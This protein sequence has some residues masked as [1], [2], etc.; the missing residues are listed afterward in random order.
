MRPKILILGGTAQA[1]AEAAR[2]TVKGDCDVITS[3]AG[4]TSKPAALGGAVRVGGFGGIDGLAQ[5]LG[6]NRITQVIDAT[7]PF[8]TRISANA[9]AACAAAGVPL[10]IL[11]RPQWLRQEDDDWREVA[12]LEQAAAS[13][14]AG[15]R[16]FLA[17]GR[18]HLGA[19]EHRQDC[20]FVVRMI[21]P[22]ARPLAFA[23][24]DLILGPPTADPQAEAALF[25]A[26]AV[27]HLVC[28]NS[29]G[30]ASYGKIVGARQLRLPVLMIAR[31]LS[32]ASQ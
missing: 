31:P 29:G 21:D 5:Y 11:S 30:E 23:D 2:L 9:V 32:A 27:T 12:S 7:H 24:C 25:A 20:H 15:A 19:F 10:E 16:A 28:R 18:Q 17:L 6:D 3:L 14:P 1:A 13:L 22:P 4:R 8:A 26:H